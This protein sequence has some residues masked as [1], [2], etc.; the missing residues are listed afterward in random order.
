MVAFTVDF[1]AAVVGGGSN[2]Q[3]QQ[4]QD[5]QTRGYIPVS[6]LGTTPMQQ[7]AIAIIFVSMSLALL[8]W[9]FRM[10]SRFSTKQLG[11]GMYAW[12][13]ALRSIS[14]RV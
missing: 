14:F 5:L 8:T 9:A 7:G 12:S 11:M 1:P 6:E 4:Q 2:V 10:Y 13:P 3:Q